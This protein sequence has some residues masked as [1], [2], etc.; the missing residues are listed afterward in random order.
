MGIIMNDQGGRS[1]LQEKL[2]AELKEKLAKAGNDDGDKIVEKIQKSPDL[3]DESA[4]VKDFQK[5]PRGENNRVMIIIIVS[6]AIL[7]LFGLVLILG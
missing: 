2:A 3:V 5:K 1:Q 6:V 4:Y 7:A